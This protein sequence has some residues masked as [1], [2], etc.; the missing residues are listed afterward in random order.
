MLPLD[1]IY[2][3]DGNIRTGRLKY[4]ATEFVSTEEVV[5]FYNTEMPKFRWEE[6]A[7]TTGESK[8]IK[9]YRQFPPGE[10]TC[11]IFIYRNNSD[12]LELFIEV[13]RK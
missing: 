9:V 8:K 1:S 2:L 12:K 13:G 6:I 11:T 3:V 7:D 4:I 10:D 5:K